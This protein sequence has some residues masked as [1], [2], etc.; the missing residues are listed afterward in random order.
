MDDICSTSVLL[1]VHLFAI[2]V[3]PLLVCSR[4]CLSLLSGLLRPSVSICR[5]CL[6]APA[7]MHPRVKP[8]ARG[9]TLLLDCET[10]YSVPQFYDHKHVVWIFV[11][12]SPR[13]Y[14]NDARKVSPVDLVA[15]GAV[16]RMPGFEVDFFVHEV[17]Y[18][19]RH[20]SASSKVDQS[21][22]IFVCTIL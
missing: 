18:L 6:V 11:R 21:E 5:S 1:F 19:G 2:L 3:E 16:W 4:W 7:L 9:G 12:T 14:V 10:A 20:L 22:V 17:R 13:L 8:P 15:G